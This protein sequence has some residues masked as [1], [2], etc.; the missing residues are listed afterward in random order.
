MTS[1]DRLTRIPV[2][3]LTTAYSIVAILVSLH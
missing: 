2:P 1:E 3:V